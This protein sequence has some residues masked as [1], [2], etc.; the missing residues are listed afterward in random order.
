M[1]DF[2]TVRMNGHDK[3]RILQNTGMS[4][5]ELLASLL[6]NYH[7]ILNAPKQSLHSPRQNNT[8][9]IPERR[10]FFDSKMVKWGGI[11]LLVMAMVVGVAYCLKKLEIIK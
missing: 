3:A 6:N 10:T 1:N 2:M 5:Q 4:E 11:A 7:N 9:D 8:I